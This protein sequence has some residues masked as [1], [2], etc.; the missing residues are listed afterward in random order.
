[1][2]RRFCAWALALC[3]IFTL[4][5]GAAPR[6]EAV[7]D[8]P[9]EI[10][11]TQECGNTCTLSSAAMMLRAR[12]YLSGSALWPGVTEAAIRSTAWYE[13]QG[14]IWYWT[15]DV[16]G[17]SMRV[18]HTSLGGIS[19]SSLKAVLDEHEEGVVLYCSSLG[20]SHAVFLTDYVGDTFYCAD[21]V[22]GYSGDRR[23]LADSLL[24]ARYGGQAGALRNASAYWY[25]A[26]YEITSDPQVTVTFDANGGSTPVSEKMVAYGAAYGELPQATWDGHVF[27]G[28]FTAA[29]GG[30][31]VTADT[32]VNVCTDHTLYAHWLPVCAGA[33]SFVYTVAQAPTQSA[34]GTLLGVCGVCKTEE[35][36]TLPPL[37]E[38]NYRY[39]LVKEATCTEEGLG[40]YTWLTTDYGTYDF[41]V[42]LAKLP[43]NNQP[44]ATQE[45]TCTEDGYTTYACQVCGEVSQGDF[46]PALGHAWDDGTVLEAP[47]QTSSGVRLYTCV[48]CGCTET[49]TIPALS[50]DGGD[51]C[52]GRRFTDMPDADNWAH[53]GIDFAVSHELFSGIT[54]TYFGAGQ[55]MDRAMLV[56]VL[57]RLENRPKT[58]AATPFVDVDDGRYYTAAVRWANANGIVDGMDETHF[59]PGND[60]TREQLA[61]ILYRYA[62]MKGYDVSAR[63]D[64]S[65]FPDAG[66]VSRFAE[67]ALSWAIAEGIV[68]GSWNAADGLAYLSP[69]SSATRAQVASIFMRLIN[70]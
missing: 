13:G 61:S 2:R 50:C 54:D 38:E 15:Y 1:M 51:D 40:R 44:I 30:D 35:S 69:K 42:A 34:S 60:V 12:M 48:R 29:D 43:H 63:G 62:R 66:Q 20:Q 27:D 6:A 47:T 67:T 64:L 70:S 45:A 26:S 4:V 11:L 58:S 18:S 33:H 37:D 59:C 25:I 23:P 49:E 14:L 8:L 7:G 16:Q 65:T 31:L 22:S 28:W 68:S 32:E 39:T 3:L 57:W 52:P 5:P 55:F 24:G 56:T 46:V 9:P 10:F 19:V 17:N 53:A 41:D 36:H 21:P